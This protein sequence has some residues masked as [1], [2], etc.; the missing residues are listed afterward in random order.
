MKN[1]T[2]DLLAL[3]PYVNLYGLDNAGKVY[4]SNGTHMILVDVHSDG[5][6]TLVSMASL[7]KYSLYSI[8]K[9]S[10]YSSFIYSPESWTK[11]G[12]ALQ[13]SFIRNLIF[14]QCLAF[15]DKAQESI[16]FGYKH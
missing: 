5:M 13:A 8:G 1:L 10:I 6:E 16:K 9:T 12:S 2:I 4:K 14:F 11:V 3:D 15:L 7:P